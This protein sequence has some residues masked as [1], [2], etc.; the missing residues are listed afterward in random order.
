MNNKIEKM[1]VTNTLEFLTAENKRQA[2]E[3]ERLQAESEALRQKVAELEKQPITYKNQPNNQGAW[4]LGEACQTAATD[5]KCGDLI[6]RGL[7]LLLALQNK[8]YGVVPLP[9]APQEMKE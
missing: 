2:A 5:P 7:I 8:G 9:T 1:L 4:R 3:I 6:D